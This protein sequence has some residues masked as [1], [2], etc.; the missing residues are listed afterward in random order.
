MAYLVHK[1]EIGDC[2]LFYYFNNRVRCHLLDRIMP[3]I[4]NLGGATFTVIFC[5]MLMVWGE[6]ELRLA[7]NRASL[8]LSS[9]FIVGYYLKK[10]FNR[11]RPYLVLA[12]AFTGKKLFTDYS[13]PSGHTTASFSLAVTYALSYPFLLLPLLFLAALIGISRIYLGQHYPTDVLAGSA[14]GTFS[15]LLINFILV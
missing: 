3:V 6:G 2:Q 9:S 1:L 7:A 10:L 13:F 11:P 12:K 14:V 5:F 4:T 15:A 8:A